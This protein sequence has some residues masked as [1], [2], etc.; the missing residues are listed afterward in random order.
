MSIDAGKDKA[1]NVH[2]SMGE[3][4]DRPVK[5]LR[6]ESSAGSGLELT[7]PEDELQEKDLII[8]KEEHD[9]VKED[10]DKSG[11]DSSLPSIHESE[12]AIEEE[13][14]KSGKYT[15]S[16]YTD[17]FNLA[18]D[19]V[20][21]EESHLFSEE[22]AEVFAKYRSL[23]YEAQYLYDIKPRIGPLWFE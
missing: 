22:E 6:H 23:P 11:L 10:Q 7:T 14:K 16:L 13:L 20:L 3:P 12:A 2:T 1:P 9:V 19:T 5:R 21:E 17:A 8:P 15:S 18:L 4:S